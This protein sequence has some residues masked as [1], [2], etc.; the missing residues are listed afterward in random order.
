VISGKHAE[1]NN[2]ISINP[3]AKSM[4]FGI[5]LK[6]AMQSCK[7]TQA[8]LATRSDV[9]QGAISR[10]LNGKASP[11]AEE[12]LRISQALGVSMEFLLTGAGPGPPRAASVESG[13]LKLAR[14]EAE[15]LARQL[16]E[17]EGTAARLRSFL[18]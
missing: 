7:V 15:K 5:F 6:T 4:H 10:Y 12:L 1:K 16:R 14:S 8:E 2:H 13:N 9:S 17:A 3:Q 18:G 11:K